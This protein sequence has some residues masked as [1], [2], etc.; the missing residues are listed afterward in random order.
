MA[1]VDP[2]ASI[3]PSADVEDDVI[4]GSSSRVWA[5]THLRRGVRIGND[6]IIGEGVLVDIDVSIGHR[7][8]VQSHALLYR[9]SVIADDVFIGP[10]ACLTNDRFPRATGPDGDLKGDAD[11]TVRGVTLGRGCSIGANAVV[12]AGC[13]IGD[14][15]M[16]GAGA[17]VTRNILAHAVVVGNP[18]RPIGWVCACGIRIDGDSRRCGSCHRAYRRSESGLQLVDPSP[19]GA[20]VTE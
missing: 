2:A 18:A 1:R 7:C 14:W 10:A 5:H 13:Q 16:V 15:A 11:W 6:C 20:A 19:P 3:H 8:K 17:V 4:V 9:G 12:V